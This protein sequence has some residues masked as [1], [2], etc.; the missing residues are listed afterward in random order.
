ML[1]VM[2]QNPQGFDLIMILSEQFAKKNSKTKSPKTK[3]SMLIRNPKWSKQN[4][5]R[6]DRTVVANLQPKTADL[7]LS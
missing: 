7:G 4:L 3:N 6:T 5:P 2:D 1:K